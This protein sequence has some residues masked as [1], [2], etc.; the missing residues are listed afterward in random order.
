MSKSFYFIC[1]LFVGL[2]DPLSAQDG[3]GFSLSLEPAV[4]FPFPGTASADGFSLGAL[5]S[6]NA[7]YV[8]AGLPF[9][10]LGGSLDYAYLPY[11]SSWRLQEIGISAGPGFRLRLL[12]ALSLTAYGR[13]GY[14][15]GMLGEQTAPNPYLRTGMEA[16]LY[17]TPSFRLSLGGEY[18]HMFAQ[19]AALYQG[20]A[21]RLAGGF[22]FSQM[23][24]RSRLELRDI[25]IFPVFPV[26]YKHY[27]DHPVGSVTLRNN[28][29]GPIHDVRVT[30][31]AK[32]YMDAPK[33]CALIAELRQGEERTVSLHTLF[34]R[35]ILSVLEPTRAQA[36][37]GVSYTYADRPREATTASV[38]AIN[39]RNAMS[40]D[41][42]DKV[43]SFATVNDP[44]VLSVSKQA[45]GIARAA[46][47]RTLDAALR[48]AVGILES[49]A[50]LGIH[51]VPDPNTPFA[52]YVKNA[53]AVDYLQFPIQTLEFR[54]GDCDDLSIL[55]CALLE[56]AGI[57][58]AFVTIP[59]H[60]YLAFALDMASKAAEGFFSRPDELIARDGKAWVP[61]E[62]TALQEGFLRA[63]QLGARQWRDASAQGEAGFHPTHA[64]WKLY[65]PVA[66]FGSESKMELPKGAALL[67]RFSAS[68][69]AFVNREIG[70]RV[71]KL[72]AEIRAAPRD[73]KPVN[74]LG[75]LYA[76]YGDYAKAEEV[77]RTALKL[78]EAASVLYNLGNVL[79]LRGDFT[80]A[81]A[82]LE[83]A[84]RLEQVDARILAALVR[85][86]Y[87]LDDRTASARWLDELVRVDPQAAARFAYV[88][89]GHA[90]SGRA[91]AGEEEGLPW[92]E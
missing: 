38:A 16:A 3:S 67:E 30:F 76:R 15:L 84:A 58:T 40:W 27:I 77:F 60:I 52:E 8:F 59:G 9:L 28:E 12:P 6:L 92:A 43:A 42:T 26:F 73:H 1:L 75:V 85:A 20:I 4:S 61:V 29:K 14:A 37:V 2:A 23:D 68:M 46:G 13:G 55:C 88:K 35:S 72:N 71:E 48:Q 69:K 47:W 65:E 54:A 49:V 57:E 32:Q 39:H 79:M 44:A 19:S 82:F 62:V 22:N 80:A 36:E 86:T 78:K 74:R 83:R 24:Q 51:Y 21:V 91:G 33:E 63:W 11:G 66:I 17:L 10:L 50:L 25:I 34:T 18:V 45:A 31:F 87:E 64:A 5:V 81:R 53:A 7:D 89:T 90:A 70:P 56:A 41:V